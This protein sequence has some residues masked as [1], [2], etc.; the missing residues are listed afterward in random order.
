MFSTCGTPGALGTRRGRWK[1]Q[2][3]VLDQ[4]TSD[5]GGVRVVVRMDSD[6]REDE[7]AGE[8]SGGSSR[9]PSI[10]SESSEATVR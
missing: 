2:F 1:C 9:K 3:L 5:D 6:E 8:R 7:R 4:S 10:S